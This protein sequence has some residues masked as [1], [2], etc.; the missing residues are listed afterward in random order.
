MCYIAVINGKCSSSLTF[1][2]LVAF[3]PCVGSIIGDIIAHYSKRHIIAWEMDIFTFNVQIGWR[4]AIPL[5][6]ISL[7]GSRHSDCW[8][9][10]PTIE[11]ISCACWFGRDID[12]FAITICFFYRNCA[13][14]PI[15]AIRIPYNGIGVYTPLS[16]VGN[17]LCWHC[18]R[19]YRI[20]TNK[21]PTLS[22]Q[23]GGC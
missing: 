19:H 3:L 21:C 8:S 15:T 7:V 14:T 23:G 1:N 5:C 16:H 11:G 22:C 17:I 2:N 4:N 18:S 6:C 9:R 12:L 13:T 10:T 20:P